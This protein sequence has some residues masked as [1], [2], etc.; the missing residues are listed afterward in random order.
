MEHP[1]VSNPQAI[2]WLAKSTKSPDATFTDLRGVRE[3]HG[4]RF[5]DASSHG[6]RQAL[7]RGDGARRKNNVE[8]H[9]GYILAR[10]RMM[11]N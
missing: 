1:D 8:C 2:L 4:E 9:S 6:H 3:V 5:D 11:S 10:F 7:E